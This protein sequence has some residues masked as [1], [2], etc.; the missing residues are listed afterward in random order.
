MPTSGHKTVFNEKH[1]MAALST[2][3]WEKYQKFIRE[4][5]LGR[6]TTLEGVIL[7]LKQNFELEVTKNQLEYRCRLWNYRKN[8][9]TT[10]P[11][12]AERESIIKFSPTKRK[13]E[14]VKLEH[15]KPYK[16]PKV[17]SPATLNTATLNTSEFLISPPTINTQG[18]SPHSTV[19]SNKKTDEF[20]APIGLQGPQMLAPVA[21]LHSSPSGFDADSA[22]WIPLAPSGPYQSGDCVFTSGFGGDVGPYGQDLSTQLLWQ[23]TFEGYMGLGGNPGVPGFYC[24]DSATDGIGIWRSPGLE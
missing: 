3:E 21:L 17:A 13:K 22:T 2:A 10:D 11:R 18:P 9:S 5:Y 20:T 23:Q 4:E 15:K 24:S 16:C 8:L 1:T 12:Q 14:L 19:L 6:N 7:L